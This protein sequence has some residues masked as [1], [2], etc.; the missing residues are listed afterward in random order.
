MNFTDAEMEVYRLQP[1]DLLLSEASGS[2]TE[3]GKPAIW[4]G[5]IEDCAFQN[6]LLRVRPGPAVDPR[7]LLQYL[8]Q[9]ASSAAFGRGSRGVG[10]HHLGREALAKWPVPLPSIDEQ[11]RIAAILDHADALRAEH[12][13]VLPSLD[14]LSQSIFHEL[15]LEGSGVSEKFGDIVDV[16]SSLVDPTESRYQTFP[17]IGPDSIKSGSSRIEGWRTVGADGVTSGKYEFKAG[18]VLYS[19]IRPNLNKVAVASFDGLCSAD[20]YAL[21]PRVEVATPEFI[22]FTLRS[23][24]FLAYAHK[25]SN[26]ANIPK[27]NRK[28]LDAFV[29]YLPSLDVQR[30]FSERLNAIRHQANTVELAAMELDGLFGSLQSRAFSGE[31]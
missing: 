18:D 5:E 20:M 6:T 2:P 7:Y 14:A 13:Q 26:R 22:E 16:R 24:K 11:H 3:V 29:V 28:Q 1:G 23:P 9:Q 4:M 31:L 21:Q 10:I 12:R 15:T 25:L 17:H 8:R 19:K 30:R 27:L